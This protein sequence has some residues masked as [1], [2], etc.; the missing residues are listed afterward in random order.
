MTNRTDTL[1]PPAPADCHMNSLYAVSPLDGRYAGRT[2]PLREYASE[3]A[4]M[5]ARVQVEVEYLI[6]LADLDATPLE[7][8]D[9]HREYLQ[10]LYEEFDESDAELIKQI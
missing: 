2:E 9:D 10:T 8:R 3:A 1:L 5:R 6:A 7:I 4:L